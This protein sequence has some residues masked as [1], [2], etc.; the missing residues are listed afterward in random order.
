MRKTILVMVATAILSI[1]V[2]LAA[3]PA[4]AKPSCPKQCRTEFVST[5]KSCKSTCKAETDKTAKKACKQTCRTDFKAAKAKCKTATAP[6]F[7]TC[8]PS[9]AFIE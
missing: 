3:S 4:L 1:G 2:S 6:V 5:F 9:G 8:S 7:P